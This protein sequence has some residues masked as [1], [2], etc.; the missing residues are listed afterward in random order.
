MRR[1][2]F[3]FLWLGSLF[4]GL[5]LL[6]I[7]AAILFV[8]LMGWT[9]TAEPWSSRLL[10]GLV[11][12]LGIFGALAAFWSMMRRSAV[13]Y[14]G[15]LPEDARGDGGGIGLPLGR[16]TGGEHAQRRARPEQRL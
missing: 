10:M 9:G 11:L 6:V 12:V 15:Q 3:Q 16:G 5:L 2:T 7:C 1:S 8:L 4:L 13:W 14:R